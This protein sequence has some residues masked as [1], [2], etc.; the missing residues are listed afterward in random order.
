VGEGPVR[1]ASLNPARRLHFYRETKKACRLIVMSE[2]VSSL[3]KRNGGNTLGFKTGTFP[4]SCASRNHYLLRTDE[5]NIV[6]IRQPVTQRDSTSRS[7]DAWC[8]WEVG[9]SLI[10][11]FDDI[12]VC[13]VA[14]F[15]TGS[16]WHSLIKVLAYFVWRLEWVA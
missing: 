8:S 11:Y 2:D 4:T 16:M 10:H 9:E 15:G 7:L 6:S 1:A 5:L 14:D 13:R 3:M 12:G